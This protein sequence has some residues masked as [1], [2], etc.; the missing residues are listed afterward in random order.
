MVGGWKNLYWLLPE[1]SGTLVTTMPEIVT[2]GAENHLVGKWM[3]IPVSSLPIIVSIICILVSTKVQEWSGRREPGHVSWAL[4]GAF[5]IIY[6]KLCII[7]LKAVV[8]CSL[9]SPTQ[10]HQI[11]RIRQEVSI[12]RACA[13][14]LRVHR[15]TEQGYD[16]S[17]IWAAG[18]L[19]FH[20]QEKS[21]NEQN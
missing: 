17:C 14:S 9:P 15:L 4:W 13:R 3:D 2:E 8:F 5:P 20:F 12:S 7:A 19:E 18:E 1:V 16:S 21:R 11:W 6:N 10:G